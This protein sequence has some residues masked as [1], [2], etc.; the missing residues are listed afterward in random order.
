MELV[1]LSEVEM[2]HGSVGEGSIMFH[3]D[4][5]AVAKE[6]SDVQSRLW[7][8]T[9]SLFGLSSGTNLWTMVTRQEQVNLVS[10]SACLL[11]DWILDDGGIASK[12][13]LDHFCLHSFRM[14]L[15][16][17]CAMEPRQVQ[18][19][20]TRHNRYTPTPAPYQSN[21]NLVTTWSNY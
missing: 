5:E 21:I 3:A 20:N 12:E 14:K 9:F 4:E 10:S 8:Y 11:C 15:Y 19:S 6:G 13:M 2:I 18:T 7:T 16:L 17:N 1:V